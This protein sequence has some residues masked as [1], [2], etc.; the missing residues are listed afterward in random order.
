MAEDISGQYKQ[1]QSAVSEIPG[2]SFRVRD[3]ETAKLIMLKAMRTRH[4]RPP[5]PG[6]DYVTFKAT[7]ASAVEEIKLEIH[8]QHRQ[9]RAEVQTV[10]RDVLAAVKAS[11]AEYVELL[12]EFGAIFL[13]FSL[14]V[15]F[16]LKI[17]LVNT[18]FALFMLPAL[19]LYW[20]MAR[21]KQASEKRGHENPQS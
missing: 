13:L 20:A 12:C 19:A 16:T 10:R 4:R 3:F 17:E 2:R 7:I 15:R 18:A 11:P 5:G 21:L 1:G 9:T 8:D 6:V 14:A